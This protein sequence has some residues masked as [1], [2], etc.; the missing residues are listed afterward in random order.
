[1]GNSV[2]VKSKLQRTGLKS[3]L[4]IHRCQS[5]KRWKKRDLWT[6]LSSL[7][8]AQPLPQLHQLISLKIFAFFSLG[9][10]A[11]LDLDSLLQGPVHEDVEGEEELANGVVEFIP[12]LTFPIN[13]ARN[14]GKN[15]ILSCGVTS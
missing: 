8:L 2:F 1:M 10:D 5:G 14:R 9:N 15:R 11:D 13:T 3:N 12:I 7:F 6:I 4:C